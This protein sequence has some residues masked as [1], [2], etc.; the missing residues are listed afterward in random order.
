MYK[1]VGIHEKIAIK[2]VHR[3][4]NEEVRG[5]K[6][7]S[8]GTNRITEK[9]NAYKNDSEPTK[10]FMEVFETI[11]LSANRQYKILEI[12]THVP[13]DI[14]AHVEEATLPQ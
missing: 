6:K 5:I 2:K 14:Q 4:M 10:D 12:I 1:D 9:G 3:V 11:T 7:S 8:R 13:E